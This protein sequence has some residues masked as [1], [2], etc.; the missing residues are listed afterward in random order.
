VYVYHQL[1]AHGGREFTRR[2][3]MAR[4]RLKRYGEGDIYP[5]ETT[6]AAAK[7][8]RLKL[9]RAC[10]A[11]LSQIFALYQDPKNEAQRLL[12]AAIEDKTPVEATDHLGVV[13]RIWPVTDVKTIADVTAAMGPK[14]LFIADG[15][16][17]YETACNY[18]DELAEAGT[19]DSQH[20]AN[21]VLMMC[22]SMD[23]PGLIVLPTHRLLRGLPALSS[24][25]LI[26]KL[27]PA[28]SSEIAATG[29]D[30]AGDVWELIEQQGEQGVLGLFAAQDR[31]WVLA[32][33]SDAGRARMAET[34]ADHS[35]QWRELGVS[36]LHHLVLEALSPPGDLPEPKYVHLVDELI[37]ALRSEGPYPLAALV[38]PASLQHIRAVCQRGERMPPKSTYFFPKLL[39]G[40]VINPLQ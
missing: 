16:H 12:E 4:V 34:A 25:E 26:E 24:A 15:H 29:G 20:P 18:Q 7:A 10:R 6:H 32:R 23:D 17:R 8:D 28:F 9:T 1:F 37:E 31:R 5:H 27:D 36:I 38:A 40:L 13:H 35:P 19:L 14:P 39:S 3:F 22:V 21:Y 33:I 11:N 30:R 2:G